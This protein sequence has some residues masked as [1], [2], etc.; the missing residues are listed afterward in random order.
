MGALCSIILT[1]NVME[2][3]FVSTS[4]DSRTYFGQV[5]ILQGKSD[6]DARV[7]THELGDGVRVLGCA[8]RDDW[9]TLDS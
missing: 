2:L 3:V 5:S 9:L 7:N 8:T 6:E 1:V 4:H